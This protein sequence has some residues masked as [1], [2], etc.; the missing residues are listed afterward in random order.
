L[1]RIPTDATGRGKARYRDDVLPRILSA[2]AQID[3]M[4]LEA[5]GFARGWAS[6]SEL[7]TIVFQPG[8]PTDNLEDASRHATLLSARA[9]STR[10]AVTELHPDWTAEQIDAEVAL[11]SDERSA[12]ST[13]PFA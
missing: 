13:L 4:P 1:R 8:L 6:P 11:I 3:A 12:T 5:G 2:M 9:E 10:Q 7:P